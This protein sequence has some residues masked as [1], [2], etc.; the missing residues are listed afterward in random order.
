[1]V[2]LLTVYVAAALFLIRVSSAQSNGLT[3]ELASVVSDSS[4]V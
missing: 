1:M 4:C 2:Y 3:L